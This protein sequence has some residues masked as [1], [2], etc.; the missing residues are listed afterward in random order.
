M[1][2]DADS[3][4]LQHPSTIFDSNQYQMHGSLFWPD[5]QAAG[6]ESVRVV[7]NIE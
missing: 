4:P 3:Q 5:Y 7:G 2:L 1:M 6:G